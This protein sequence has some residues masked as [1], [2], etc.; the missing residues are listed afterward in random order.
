MALLAAE[1]ELV[2]LGEIDMLAGTGLRQALGDPTRPKTL[3][4]GCLTSKCLGGVN[5]VTEFQISSF[6]I[7]SRLGIT[8]ATC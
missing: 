3:Q 6:Q 1:T 4:L 2:L 5:V 8:A 7:T